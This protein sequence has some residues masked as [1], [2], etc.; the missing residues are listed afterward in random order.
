VD[1]EER[2]LVDEPADEPAHVEGL[3]LAGRDQRPQVGR[4]RLAGLRRWRR[5]LPVL[6]QV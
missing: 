5:L 3:A 1:L 2:V 6:R 4:L